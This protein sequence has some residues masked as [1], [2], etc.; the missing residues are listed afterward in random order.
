MAS[1]DEAFNYLATNLG[2]IEWPP[3]I[4]HT[5]PHL[6][7]AFLKQRLENLERELPLKLAGNGVTKFFG[8]AQSLEELDKMEAECKKEADAIREVFKAQYDVFAALAEVEGAGGEPR[9]LA[10]SHRDADLWVSRDTPE[11]VWRDD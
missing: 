6:K 5:I 11:P 9:R 1:I 2:V 4:V 7:I 8:G 10:G 3:Q